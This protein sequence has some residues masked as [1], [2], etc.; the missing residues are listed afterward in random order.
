ML[1]S[2]NNQR[3]RATI[4]CDGGFLPEEMIVEVLLQ[5]P[6][7][8]I[9]RFRVVNRSWAALFA[10]DEFC[11]LYMVTPQGYTAKATVCLTHCNI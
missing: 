3:K 1:S 11:R 9:M 5:L 6:V 4:S 7:K 10:V 2:A 8:S